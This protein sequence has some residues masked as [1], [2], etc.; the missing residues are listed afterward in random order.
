MEATNVKTDRE[1]IQSLGS[2]RSLFI[3]GAAGVYI[4]NLAFQAPA[5][6]ATPSS[7]ISFMADDAKRTNLQA[8]KIAVENI[9]SDQEVD[10]LSV[11]KRSHFSR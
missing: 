5:N 8:E 9:L 6:I 2:R 7:E 11:F 1:D 3:E 10:R 4:L